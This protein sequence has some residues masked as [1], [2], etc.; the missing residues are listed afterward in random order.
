MLYLQK[1]VALKTIRFLGYV[2]EDIRF[3]R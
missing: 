3:T 1:V 2:S